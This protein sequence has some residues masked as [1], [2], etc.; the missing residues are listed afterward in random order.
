MPN[1]LCQLAGLD[2]VAECRKARCADDRITKWVRSADAKHFVR[3][4]LDWRK[5]DVLLQLD[6]AERQRCHWGLLRVQDGLLHLQRGAYRTALRTCDQ[7][8][9]DNQPIEG[10]LELKGIRAFAQ[11]RLGDWT[12]A[13]QSFA[14]LLPLVEHFIRYG[15]VYSNRALEEQCFNVCRVYIEVCVDDL[16]LM[17]IDLAEHLASE[18]NIS[19]VN[20][21]L[22]DVRI[23]IPN[24]QDWLLAQM[25]IAMQSGSPGTVQIWSG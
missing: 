20:G 10:V 13:R 24:P 7:I 16:Q 6:Y 11:W 3:M 19:R 21:W 14:N 1:L 5:A 17:P 4:L 18:W 23:P 12:G 22:K 8:L 2:F 25:R 9:M 15:C